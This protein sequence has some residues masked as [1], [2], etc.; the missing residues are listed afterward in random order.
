MDKEKRS[1]EWLLSAPDKPNLAEDLT[2]EELNQLGAD[3]VRTYE[4]DASDRKEWDA[5]S[6]TAMKLAE[7]VKEAK[8]FPWLN[9]ANV[10]H[11]LITVAGIQFAARAYP[12]IVKGNQV[13]KCQITGDEPLPASL[14][15]PMPSPDRGPLPG[16]VPPGQPGMPTGPVPSIQPMQPGIPPAPPQGVPGM[17]GQTASIP[18]S[19][20]QE[21][22]DRIQCHMNFQLTQQM[23]E[24]DEDMDRALHILPV[25]GQL[26]KKSYFHGNWKRNVSELVLPE[27]CVLNRKASQ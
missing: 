14:L 10:K 4:M 9:A 11:P 6:Q 7:Q 21:R 20:K 27:D 26:Y 23:P 12:E 24:W 1:I 22:A 19:P 5:L 17:V 2:Q 8:S 25:L 13:V 15:P 3:V 16:M 18:I